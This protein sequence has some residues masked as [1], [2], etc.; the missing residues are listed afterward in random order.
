[1]SIPLH[2][3]PPLSRI[4]HLSLFH[5]HLLLP[6]LLCSSFFRFFCIYHLSPFF[7]H[8]RDSGLLSSTVVF[9]FGYISYLHSSSVS[10]ILNCLE[11]QMSSLLLPCSSLAPIVNYLTYL[12][13]SS[14][15]SIPVCL[16]LLF[17]L[18]NI[19]PLSLPLPFPPFQ[20]ALSLIPMV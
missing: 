8:F 17:P 7:F 20:S 10:S 15:P 12:S 3:S 19:S 13:S 9:T 6:G 5:F 18:F 11:P 16:C 1:M 2:C 4:S 14:I